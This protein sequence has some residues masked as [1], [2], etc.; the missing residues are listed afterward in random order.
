M[1]Y[2]YISEIGIK[3]CN[4]RTSGAS[5]CLGHGRRQGRSSDRIFAFGLEAVVKFSNLMIV[6]TTGLIDLFSVIGKPFLPLLGLSYYI[7]MTK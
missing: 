6:H 1:G 5:L 3:M 4:E 2:V 7:S